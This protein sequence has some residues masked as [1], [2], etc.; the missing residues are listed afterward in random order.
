M[1]LDY[2]R[3]GKQK[4]Y[5]SKEDVVKRA[6]PICASEDYS[7][8]CRERGEIGIVKCKGCGLIYVNPMVKEPEKNYWGDPEKYHE[9]ARLIFEGKA[10]HHRD[11][12]YLEDLKIIENVKPE[13]RF[14]DIGTNMGFF[15]R[16]AIGKKWDLF[17]VEP[18]PSLSEMARKY[19][20]LN[21]KTC[22]LEE[23][24]FD[25][26]FFD[27]VTMTDVFEH[28]A[29]PK[30]IVAEI[31][32]VLKEKGIL[33]IKVPNVK[34]NLLKL[35]LAKLTG[36]LKDYDIFDS[37]EHVVHYDHKALAMVLKEAGF[38]IRKISTGRPIQLPAWH[39]YV[40]HYYLYPSPWTLDIKN[41]I[42]RKI[43]YYLSVIEFFLRAGSVGYFSSN[44]IVIAEKI[45]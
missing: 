35:F 19:F 20:N 8:I 45:R 18:S 42:T 43:F 41:F 38:K 33:F 24:G 32:R 39:K 37:Y 36:R 11:P 6:C 44:I 7:T 12:N 28:I 27:I 21:V 40:G 4:D 2:Q 1:N 26:D 16:N 10:A 15:L 14:L 30:K 13:G 34:Y 3:G 5:Y 23:A 9:E 22:Y 29:E 17:G 31:K 25:S